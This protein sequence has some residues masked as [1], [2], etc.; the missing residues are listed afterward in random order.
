M[1]KLEEEDGFVDR[2]KGVTSIFYHLNQIVKHTVLS[3]Q[4][5][6]D[7]KQ[8]PPSMFQWVEFDLK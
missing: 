1:A 8:K 6:R 5:F 3:S 7:G 4:L 2:G